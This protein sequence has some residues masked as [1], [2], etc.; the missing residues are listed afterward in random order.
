LL[1]PT[2]PSPGVSMLHFFGAEAGTLL[3][4]QPEHFER[5]R[6]ATV[7][8]WSTANGLA[9]PSQKS[10]IATST[11]IGSVDTTPFFPS[12]MLLNPELLQNPNVQ[13]EDLV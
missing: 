9:K 12:S 7:R 1:P 11:P 4:V 13:Q 3:W 10:R 5:V 2:S 8:L 6:A